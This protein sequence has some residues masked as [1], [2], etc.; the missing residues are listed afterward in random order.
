[1]RPTIQNCREILARLVSLAERAPNIAANTEDIHTAGPEY[2]SLMNSFRMHSVSAARSLEHL[3]QAFGEDRFPTTVGYAIVRPMFEID[4]TSHYI[5]EDPAVR[6][7]RFIRFGYIV[8]KRRM[9][10]C[11][12]HRNSGDPAWSGRLQAE[13]DLCWA[14]REQDI[15]KQCDTFLSTYLPSGKRSTL[16]RYWSGLT[17]REIAEKVNHEAAYDLFYADLSSFAHADVRLP[18]RFLRINQDGMHW[19]DKARPHDVFKV[20]EYS[21]IFLECFL[22]LFGRQFGSWK[23]KELIEVWRS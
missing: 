18:D 13:W 17:L 1:M 8:E 21:I 4:V 3:Y 22:R 20:F 5:T 6:A 12:K 10:A 2:H 16:R 23:E 14:S 9:D 7:S 11:A 15:T 19:T